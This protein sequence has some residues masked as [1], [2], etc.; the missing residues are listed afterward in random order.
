MNIATQR[1]NALKALTES[2]LDLLI[3]GGGIVG[4]GIEARAACLVGDRGGHGAVLAGTASVVCR[5]IP[6]PPPAR[7]RMGAVRAAAGQQVVGLTLSARNRL[8]ASEVPRSRY[9]LGRQDWKAE[10]R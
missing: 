8:L 3:I 10:T 5:S 2:P 6:P 7:Q 9:P 4:A 1:G